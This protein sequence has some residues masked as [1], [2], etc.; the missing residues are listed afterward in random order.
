MN[1]FKISCGS[2]QI[3]N[4]VVEHLVS[5]GYMRCDDSLS[6]DTAT[7]I[8]VTKNNAIHSGVTLETF[9]K[10][11]NEEIDLYQVFNVLDKV[12]PIVQL[13]KSDIEKILGYKINIV[14]G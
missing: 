10:S 1:N 11:R 13:T 8:Y 4:I 7:F 9:D 14:K 5:L 3:L 2:N 6:K 12:K